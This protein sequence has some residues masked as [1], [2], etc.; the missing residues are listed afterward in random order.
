MVFYEIYSKAFRWLKTCTELYTF[1]CGIHVQLA[2]YL[3]RPEFDVG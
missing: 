1:R 3:M 2:E